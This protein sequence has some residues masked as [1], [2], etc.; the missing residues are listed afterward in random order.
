[1]TSTVLYFHRY[2]CRSMSPNVTNEYPIEFAQYNAFVAFLQHS[3]VIKYLKKEC[4]SSIEIV[5]LFVSDLKWIY[6]FVSVTNN[7]NISLSISKV[8]AERGGRLST[9]K[10]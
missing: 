8:K 4:I 9:L 10:L 6:L 3:L 2:V 5:F 7:C 1:M